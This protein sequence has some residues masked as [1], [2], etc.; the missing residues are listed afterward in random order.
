MNKKIISITLILTIILNLILPK[1]IYAAE[2]GASADMQATTGEDIGNQVENF[3]KDGFRRFFEGSEATVDSKGGKRVEQVLLSLSATATVATILSAVFAI[4]PTIVN[5]T[6]NIITVLFQDEKDGNLEAFFTIES[7]VFNRYT[8]FKINFFDINN[9]PNN[10][11]QTLDV[12]KENVAIW[13]FSLRNIAIVANLIILVYIGIRMII[14]SIAT[15]KAK[16]K[17]MLFNWVMSFVLLFLMHYML[18]A[19]FV[20]HDWTINFLNKVVDDMEVEQ[21]VEDNGGNTQNQNQNQNQNQGQTQ[22]TD[23]GRGFEEEILEKT[24]SKL[25]I[26]RGWDAMAVAITLYILVYHELK[27]F[28][29]YFKRLI[30]VGFLLIISP[31]ITITYAIDAVKDGKSQVYQKW[32]KEILFNVFIQDIHAVTYAVFIF[33]AGEIAKQEPIMAAI[34]FMTLSRTVKIIR[35]TLKLSSDITKSESLIKRFRKGKN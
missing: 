14:S 8:L 27:F 5:F 20:F 3:W 15:E 2:G 17:H 7:L 16:Y 9:N 31:L 21:N 29:M 32:L 6:M 24:W 28:L 11:K 18:A 19:I 33:S 35:T 13:Y 23:K 12:L 34:L 4:F 1:Y 22:N 25:L 30:S 26:L 10:T